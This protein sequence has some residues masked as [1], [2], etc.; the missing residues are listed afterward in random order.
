MNF[1]CSLLLTRPVRNQND[2]I[3]VKI[4]DFGLAREFKKNEVDKY[5]TNQAGTFHWMAPE[6]M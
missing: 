4:A 1:F 6:V 3:T 2:Y 5:Q